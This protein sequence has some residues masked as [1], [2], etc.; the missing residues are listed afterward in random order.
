[1]G[2]SARRFFTWVSPLFRHGF[3]HDIESSDLWELPKH[4]CS[5]ELS[6]NILHFIDRQ[7][8]CGRPLSVVRAF[9]SVFALK[10]LSLTFLVGV[11]I[12]AQTMAPLFLATIVR[13]IRLGA[14]RGA[15]PVCRQRAR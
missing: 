12:T 14:A 7:R 2:S 8:K 10:F 11:D 9:C 15:G 1:V 3:R 6:D 4:Q 13:E 5:Q